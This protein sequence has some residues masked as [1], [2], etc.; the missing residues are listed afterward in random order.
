M[1]SFK[2][3][4]DSGVMTVI[5]IFKNEKVKYCVTTFSILSS[6]R[7]VST[8]SKKGIAYNSLVVNYKE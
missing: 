4:E 2:A 6:M 7:I 8:I 1:A 5:I 3:L